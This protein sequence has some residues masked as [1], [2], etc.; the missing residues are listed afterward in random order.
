MFDHFGSASPPETADDVKQSRLDKLN[1]R[2]RKRPA[3]DPATDPATSEVNIPT[4]GDADASNQST[5]IPKESTKKNKNKNKNKKKGKKKGPKDD[6]VTDADNTADQDGMEMVD[7]NSTEQVL[8]QSEKHDEADGM[9]VDAVALDVTATPPEHPPETAED[10]AMM[11]SAFM[12]P[13]DSME[14][15]EFTAEDAGLD[16]APEAPQVDAGLPEWLAHPTVVTPDIDAASLEDLPE[17][18]L[19]A[20]GEMLGD[21]L[22]GTCR[23]QGIHTLFAGM[24]SLR[25]SV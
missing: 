4:A 24:S 23:K 25:M 17:A 18:Q 21:K 11:Q 14:D 20:F 12:N 15:V 9:D 3:A 8:Q 19:D 6:G 5:A 1:N 10:L 22:V 13:F 2:K 16:D 7:D